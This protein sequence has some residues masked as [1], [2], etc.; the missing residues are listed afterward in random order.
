[1]DKSFDLT[2]IMGGVVRAVFKNF[3]SVEKKRR[4]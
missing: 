3:W 1:M 2:S 4:G